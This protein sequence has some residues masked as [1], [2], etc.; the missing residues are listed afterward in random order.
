MRGMDPDKAMGDLPGIS[1]VESD[2]PGQ[3]TECH[4]PWSPAIELMPA[5]LP[6]GTMPVGWSVHADPVD[7]VR[8]TLQ[9]GLGC[10]ELRPRDLTFSGPSL[11]S[12][13]REL[14]DDRPLFLSYHLTNLTWNPEL[15]QIEG[16]EAFAAS[17]DAALE[18]GVDSLTVHVPVAPASTMEE[19]TSGTCAPTQLYR[20]FAGVT[21]EL[22]ADAA[23]AGVRIAI[24]NLHNPRNTPVG[25]PDLCFATQ[26]DQYLRWIDAMVAQLAGVPNAA[27]GAHLDV[28]HARNNGGELDNLQPL[29]D[30]YAR[31][32]RRILGYHIHQVRPDPDRGGLA[33]HLGID[34]LFGGRL[35]FAGFLWAWSMRQITRGPLFIEVRDEEARLQ[36][37]RLLLTLFERAGDIRQATD[38]P[39]R[40]G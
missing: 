39:G 14:R 24:E 34:G 15:G 5:D 25:S 37:A 20:E 12:A 26:I 32:G 11:A 31:L 19:Q 35:S 40:A 33:N 9:S 4:V 27:V 7:A 2:C 21:A 13:L 10:L 6:D 29:G 36:T 28:G 17:V 18:A 1:L 16:R 30:W 22:L 38:L 3:W 8:Q 23:R